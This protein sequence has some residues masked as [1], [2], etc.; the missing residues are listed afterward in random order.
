MMV[1]YLKK[2]SMKTGGE[3]EKVYHQTVKKVTEDYEALAFQY[4]DFTNDGV[5]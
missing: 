3:F 1:H 4:S 2:L 5:Y